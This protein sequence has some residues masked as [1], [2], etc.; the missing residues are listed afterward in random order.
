MELVFVIIGL[1]A[2]AALAAVYYVQRQKKL[3]PVQAL[4]DMQVRLEQVNSERVRQ[5]EKAAFLATEQQRLNQV[6]TDEQQQV[7]HATIQLAG[8]QSDLRNLE[9][10][11]ATQQQELEK[12]HKQLT[13]QFENIA[14][15]I[16][17]GSAK[18]V[19]E[20]QQQ[21]LGEILNPLKERIEKFE[22]KVDATHKENI[23]DNQS[24]KEQL[25]ML[26]KLNQTIGEEAKNLT[27]ALKGQTKTQGNWGEFILESLLERSGLSKG[28]EYTVQQSL[29][30][31]QGR[32]LQPDVLINL[33]DMKTLVVD[34]KVSLVAYERYSS[35]DNDQER[36][37]FLAEH[38]ASVKKH[39]RDLS[40]KNYQMLYQLQSLDFVMM[41]VPVE[42]AFTVAVQADMN[43][44]N[45]AYERN[46]V[47]V[48]PST[49]LATLRTV[50][51]IWRQEYQ[52]Q[53]AQE[54]ARQSG[55]LYDKFVGL[56][57]DLTVVG[58]R[59]KSTQVA[60]DEV[61]KK[62]SGRDNLVRK[63][64]KLRLMG[65]RTSKQ[66]PR[67]FLEDGPETDTPEL[68]LGETEV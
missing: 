68:P 48:S 1:V 30:D 61:V 16:L 47:I 35:S 26:Q 5:E 57:N 65:A 36:A 23:R 27:S 64:E 63:V 8:A 52:N 51:S 33:P 53:N 6:L 50:A 13:E 3:V 62:L 41:F 29:T 21:R 49:L 58:N 37:M 55:D 10:K 34:A 45:E 17:T 31:E 28:R 15:R 60:Y 12:V 22:N 40:S 7:K 2:G 59:L 24:L 32:R 38:L 19:Q 14:S 46:I 66:I 20:Q 56:L 44:F 9:E 39:I 54:I 25:Q 42:P 18:Y 67:S 11:L 4:N 43:L